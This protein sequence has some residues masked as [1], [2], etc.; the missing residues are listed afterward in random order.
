M[1]ENK[2]QIDQ[3]HDAN[4]RYLEA[5]VGWVRLSLSALA[6]NETPLVRPSSGSAPR[7]S[8]NSWMRWF[9]DRPAPPAAQEPARMEPAA[10]PATTPA[11]VSAARAA[12]EKEEASES[13]PALAALALH[14]GLSQFE[15]NL[16]LLCVAHELDTR[17]GPLCARV[18]G[19]LQQPYPTFDLAMGLFG[20]AAWDARSPERPLRYWRLIEI[21]PGG[22]T[23]GRSAL[24]ADDRIVDFV[25][26]LNYLDERLLPLLL[27][28][29]ASGA[30]D[31]LSE[32]QIELAERIART[33]GGLPAG[34]RVPMVQ[35][36]GTD[37]VSQR[38]VAAHAAHILGLALLRLS[39]EVL[40][41]APAEL[42]NL[43]RLWQRENLLLPLALL[44]EAADGDMAQS[45]NSPMARFLARLD[46]VVLL[47]VREP[48]ARLDRPYQI[49]DTARPLPPEQRAFWN[50]TL[51]GA[52]SEALERLPGQFDLNFPS[53]HQAVAVARAGDE[54]TPLESRLWSACRSLTRPRLQSLA[55]RIDAKATWE[56]LV[57]P[58]DALALLHHLADQVR[59]RTR[60]YDEW[61]F[62]ARMNRGLGIN[63]LFSGESGSGK[64]MAAEVIA[65]DLELD[66]YRIDLSAVVSKYIGETEKNLRRVFDA[67]EDGG[68]ILFFDEA[69]ALFGK[70]SE[71]K[72]SHDRYANIEINYLLQR[73]E[74]YRGLAILA[75]NVKQS[76]DTAFL[77]RLRFV[78]TFSFPNL[79]ERKQIWRRVFPE[80]TPLED[81]D[82]DR[83][84]RLSLTGGSIHNTALNSAF[85]A[86]RGN[87][88]ITMQDVLDAVRVEMQKL[89]QPVNEAELAP[90]LRK[91]AMV[92]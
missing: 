6:G 36:T 80:G 68:A 70:R 38:L 15:K 20:D 48:L 52:S 16:L 51:E 28:V 3:W 40:P 5:A 63:A 75:T 87:R 53:I 23:L 60:V 91:V 58:G 35:L 56:D 2:A 69:D 72:D 27:P 77:R 64:T 31:M 82:F 17:I 71:V 81:V 19:D 12:M 21:L 78:V 67:A 9:G 26:G 65:N 79:A 50:K 57:L 92:R 24:H 41:T 86:A 76:L 42:E 49:A 10:P 11:E 14:C 30:E 84:A 43:A 34:R 59:Q 32:S 25:K 83:L 74:G 29:P 66:L 7:E 88:A 8:E 39:V 18:H 46:G 37:V 13:T 4:N 73:M 1:S 89:D 90:I 62:R 33:L 54:G 44:V 45:A 47:A 85:F 61:G 22:R 55:Q